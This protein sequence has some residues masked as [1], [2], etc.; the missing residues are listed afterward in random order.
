MNKKAAIYIRVS[1]QE[2]AREGYSI[3]AQESKLK[4][5][6]KSKDYIVHKVYTDPGFSGATLERPGI[7]QL[8]RDCETHAFDIV[9]VYKLDRISRSQKNT[10][11]LIQDV[12]KPN[13]IGFLSLQ[14]SFDTSTSFGVAMVGILSVFAELERSTITER[15]SMGREERAKQGYYHGGGNYD[16]L[17]YDYIDGELEVNDYESIIVQDIFSLYIGG[18]SMNATCEIIRNKYPERI[19]SWTIVKDAIKNPL[20]TGMVRFNGNTYK[21][22]HSAIITQNEYDTAQM[23]RNKRS[24][25][26]YGTNKQK[27]LL[28]G[29]IHCARCGARYGR[30]VSG[31]KQYRYVYYKCYSRVKKASN[32]MI[33]DPTCENKHWKEEQLESLVIENIKKL[34][35][36][37]VLNRPTDENQKVYTKEISSIDTQIERL[38]DLYAL[39]S[40]DSSLLNERIERLNKEK[41]NLMNHVRYDKQNK[42]EEDNLLKSQMINWKTASLEVKIQAINVLIKRIDVD[43]TK[44]SI[45]WNI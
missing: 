13:D 25:K 18:H 5:Y 15:V 29:K 40:V 20:Y 23:I 6:A 36:A 4:S 32:N 38:I 21:G 31:T 45:T 28:V 34:N 41:S 11:H 9:L 37:E 17:G 14:E 1:T 26:I 16:P 12:F 7:Q 44:I 42:I 35:I 10:L 33:K 8:I 22:R 19:R 3:A 39:G 30:Q 2:Q 27:G 43:G 24:S